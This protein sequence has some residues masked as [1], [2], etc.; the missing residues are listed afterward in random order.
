MVEESAVVVGRRSRAEIARIAGIFRESGLGRREFCARH[1][2]GLS[3]LNRH[4]KRQAQEQRR[5]SGR[6][7]SRLVAVEVAKPG[8]GDS[9]GK[10]A[11]ML[12][13][14]LCNGR[15]V[16]VSRGFDAGTLAHLVEVL[17]RM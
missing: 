13:V 7:E 2:I 16:E 10:A 8:A 14:L 4:L 6:W 17:E 15:R 3:T 9:A 12:T 1:G 11:G 5:S